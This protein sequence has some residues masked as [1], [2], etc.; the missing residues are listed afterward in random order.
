[1]KKWVMK[2]RASLVCVC[3]LSALLAVGGW[4]PSAL[5]Q[6]AHVAA[7]YAEEAM[8]QGDQSDMPHEEYFKERNRDMLPGWDGHVYRWYGGW[9]VDAEHPDGE[10]FSYEV[11][12][13]TSSKPEVVCVTRDEWEYNG[14]PDHNWRF[15]ALARGSAS[16]EVTY[17]DLRGQTKTYTFEVRVVSDVYDVWV[18]SEDWC[19]C[20]L[21][22]STVSLRAEGIHHRE[23]SEDTKEG[24]TYE[25]QVVEGADVG[26]LEVDSQDPQHATFTVKSPSPQKM[27]FDDLVHVRVYLHD[28]GQDAVVDNGWAFEVKNTYNELW[29][30]HL[31]ERMPVGSEV[32]V[33]PEMRHYLWGEFDDQGG[34]EVLSNAEFEWKWVDTDAVSITDAAG[35]SVANGDPVGAGTYTIKRLRE[36]ETSF[37][38]CCRYTDGR[39]AEQYA[40]RQFRL[41]RLNYDLWFEGRHDLDV[42]VTRGDDGS[43]A[44]PANPTNTVLF[45]DDLANNAR[46]T[47][48]FEVGTWQDDRWQTMYDTSSNLYTVSDDGLSVTANGNEMAK[49]GIRDLRVIATCSVGN[50]DP[51]NSHNDF[52]FHLREREVDYGLKEH[53]DMLPGWDGTIDGRFDVH[54]CNEEH[55]DGAFFDCEVTDVEVVSGAEHIEDFHKDGDGQGQYWWCYRAK[56]YGTTELKVTYKDQDGAN[57][58]RNV[59]LHIDSKVYSL[60]AWQSPQSIV[61][62]EHTVDLYAQGRVQRENDYTLRDGLI[63]KWELPQSNAYDFA[64]DKDDPSHATITFHGPRDGESPRNYYRDAWPVVV[65]YDKDDEGNEIEVARTDLHVDASESFIT[66][67]PSNIDHDLDVGESVTIDPKVI[68]RHL[69]QNGEYVDE[70]LNT[71][72]FRYYWSF[73][74]DAVQVTN[75][76]GEKVTSS[77]WGASDTLA[78]EG[79][80]TI[81]RLRPHYTGL[82]FMT[83]WTNPMG[84]EGEQEMRYLLGEKDYELWFDADDYT[85]GED[86]NAVMRLDVSRVSG[87]EDYASY[88]DLQIG[89]NWDG[90]AHAFEH[91]LSKDEY[92]VEKGADVWTIHIPGDVVKQKLAEWDCPRLN[93]TAAFMLP[94]DVWGYAVGAHVFLADGPTHALTHIDAVEPTVTTAGNKEHWKCE[95]C[96]RLFLDEEGT[97]GTTLAEVAIPPLFV[98]VTNEIAHKD[99]INWLAAS[100]ISTGWQ[101]P[102]GTRQF[103]PYSDV[104]RADMAAFLFRLAR[105]WGLVAD[106]WQ[107]GETAAFADATNEGPM[108]TAHYREIMW[109]AESGIS[110]GWDMPDGTKQFRPYAN[111]ARADMA[112]FLHRLDGLR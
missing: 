33:M 110:K 87:V 17:L 28:G 16:L 69:D 32:Q 79:P 75:A 37:T 3:A 26:T 12:N 40:E 43:Y 27:G 72:E 109:L 107:P 105:S 22:G 56:S 58:S 89:S 99:D 103:R 98:D 49:Q 35:H 106:D 68:F 30:T 81:T 34:Y 84:E 42:W 108:P 65:L 92:T 104:A 39:G 50:M 60:D 21:P 101:M 83:R 18:S 70:V 5:L 67:D 31:D 100:G 11:T 90:H 102:D 36:W 7:A 80:Y 94:D 15:E 59:Y 20:V 1:M 54:V 97:Q 76:K 57:Q 41:G 71:D 62:P 55:P 38:L 88:I 53:R 23:G 52:W 96:G 47:V 25:W 19:D 10:D 64:V 85:T 9:R 45:S 82:G 111:V 6:L 63:Y 78:G 51:I 74:E 61:L 91:A 29:P 46:K 14:E 77:Q 44:E 2:K 48:A 95:K 112:A 4:S 24:L 8:P 66:V 13:V 73:D 86:C 93:V